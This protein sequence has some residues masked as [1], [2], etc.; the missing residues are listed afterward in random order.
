[1]EKTELGDKLLLLKYL[2]I[3]DNEWG[4]WLSRLLGGQFGSAQDEAF[5]SHV[6]GL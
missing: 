4:S 5:Q 2:T 6:M 1:M 3:E